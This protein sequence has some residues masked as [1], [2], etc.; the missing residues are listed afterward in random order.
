MRFAFVILAAV[1]LA[2]TAEAAPGNGPAQ[3]VFPGK[4]GKVAFSHAKHQQQ[5]Q[6]A[7]VTCHHTGEGT[8][9]CSS[10]HGTKGEAPVIKDAYHKLC[11]GCH[12]K[13]DAGP[14]NCKGCHKK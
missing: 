9:K 13:K 14:Y 7:C 8:V 12:K 4:L 1:F 11:M 5:L 3:I 10:C 2:S 6:I